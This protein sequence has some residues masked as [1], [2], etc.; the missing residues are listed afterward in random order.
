MFRWIL[1]FLVTIYRTYYCTD[2]RITAL[3]N[4]NVFYVFSG[5]IYLVALVVHNNLASASITGTDYSFANCN[6]HFHYTIMNSE[7]ETF[8]EGRNIKPAIVNKMKDEKV[9]TT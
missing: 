2:Q 7:L 9:S 3:I 8:L 1:L 5:E 4:F 6:C